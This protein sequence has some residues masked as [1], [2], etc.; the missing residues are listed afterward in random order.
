V[1]ALRKLVKKFDTQHHCQ[2]SRKLLPQVYASNFA[3][4]LPTLE[5]GLT[6]LRQALDFEEEQQSLISL[7]WKQHDAV[8][9]QRKEDVT[10]LHNLVHSIS[11]EIIC[12]IVDDRSDR[13]PLENSLQACEAAWTS[14]IQLC[15]CDVALTKD[16]KR[17]WHTMSTFRDWQG[18]SQDYCQSPWFDLSWTHFLIPLASGI[19]PPLLIDVLCTSIGA[20]HWGN[21]QLI[22]KSNPVTIYAA[23]ALARLFIR[24]PDLMKQ[25]HFIMSFDLFA[26]HTLGND[27]DVLEQPNTTNAKL[28]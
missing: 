11:A 6:T 15:E 26:M 10:W 19:R 1:E 2:L 22:L 25:C 12:H 24:H 3:V 5:A 7:E 17:V 23:K 28:R 27:L 21:S 14:G 8:I 4:G 18:V 13:R 9:E 20:G 16:E